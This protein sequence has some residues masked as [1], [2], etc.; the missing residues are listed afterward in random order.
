MSKVPDFQE[1]HEKFFQLFQKNEEGNL[2]DDDKDIMI[3]ICENASLNHI[4]GFLNEGS[5]PRNI[6]QLICSLDKKYTETTKQ[7]LEILFERSD[8]EGISIINSQNERGETALHW[9]VWSQELEIIKLLLDMEDLDINIKSNNGINDGMTALSWTGYIHNQSTTLDII[10]LF[11]AREDNN[12]N[13]SDN[14]GYTLLHWATKYC[15]EYFEAILTSE[16][17]DVNAIDI[18]NNSAVYYIVEYDKP[19]MFEAILNHPDFDKDHYLSTNEE[20]KAYHD[21]QYKTYLE[22]KENEENNNNNNK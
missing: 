16:G 10:K 19:K 14:E 2:T 13:E 6:L 9:A 4:I 11:T 22:Q 12:I 7:M 15:F 18:F 17:I 20:G 5:Y 21:N 1:P 8:N 3:K